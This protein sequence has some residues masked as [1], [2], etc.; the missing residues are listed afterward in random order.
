MCGKPTISSELPKIGQKIRID[1][2][3][4]S[5][6]NRFCPPFEE[7]LIKKIISAERTHFFLRGNDGEIPSAS[8]DHTT[9]NWTTCY[10]FFD[11]KKVKV[12]IIS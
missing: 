4:E 2:H 5:A 6:K 10:Q 9:K 11:D 12:S 8:F 3:E 7:G 1:L